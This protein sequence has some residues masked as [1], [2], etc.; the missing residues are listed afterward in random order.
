M[1]S[2]S[3][4]GKTTGCDNLSEKHH[5]DKENLGADNN[6]SMLSSSQY[7]CDNK[8]NQNPYKKVKKTH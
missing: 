8:E 5:E 7:A 3:G 6:S 1:S 2:I 4:C